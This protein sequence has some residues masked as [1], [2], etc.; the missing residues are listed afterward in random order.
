MKIDRAM[1]ARSMMRTCWTRQQ[2]KRATKVGPIKK[3]IEEP[4][5][6]PNE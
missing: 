5:E 4:L 2:L 6:A 3:D 1:K